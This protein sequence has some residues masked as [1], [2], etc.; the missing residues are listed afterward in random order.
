M[1]DDMFIS[2]PDTLFMGEDGV[3]FIHYSSH[4]DGEDPLYQWGLTLDEEPAVDELEVAIRLDIPKLVESLIDMHDNRSDVKLACVNDEG[5][6]ELLAMREQLQKAIDLIDKVKLETDEGYKILF[7][8]SFAFNAVLA[9]W[10]NSHSP[11]LPSRVLA[12]PGEYLTFRSLDHRL[13]LAVHHSGRKTTLT[14]T[15][16]MDSGEKTLLP[17]IYDSNEIS[18]IGQHIINFF[19]GQ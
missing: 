19:K 18:A 5:K 15:I 7:D 10:L 2:N 8:P 12:K 3:P 14:K 9:T 13:K 1:S 11:G 16:D 6:K 4:L 17:V